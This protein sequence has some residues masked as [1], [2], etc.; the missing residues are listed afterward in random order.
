MSIGANISVIA[1]GAVL[2][3]AV[4]VHTDGVSVHSVGGVLMAVGLISLALQISALIKQRQLTAAQAQAPG[5]TVLVRPG[6]TAWSPSSYG[7]ARAAAPLEAGES[8]YRYPDQ[9]SQNEW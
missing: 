8:P 4:R 7:Q 3:F 2:A 6:G 1:T 5:E 9:Y